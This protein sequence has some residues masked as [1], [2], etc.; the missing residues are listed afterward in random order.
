MDIKITSFKDKEFYP[1]NDDKGVFKKP[2]NKRCKIVL[3]Y[4]SPQK[5]ELLMARGK[6]EPY[7]VHKNII[8]RIENPV[9][10]TIDGVK[11]EMCVNDIFEFGELKE[12]YNKVF[13]YVGE[14]LLAEQK[15]SIS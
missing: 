3:S 5:R 4:L 11:R 2:D 10:L 12:V 6:N 9:T 8:K 7:I 14:F 15:K 13:A 1:F